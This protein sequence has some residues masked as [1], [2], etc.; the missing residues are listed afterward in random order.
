MKTILCLL[1]GL[2][3]FAC[4]KDEESDALA[5]TEASIAECCAEDGL[6]IEDALAEIGLDAESIYQLP[7]KFTDTNGKTRVL[8]DFRDRPVVVAMIFTH[9]EYACPVIIEDLHRFEAGLSEAE[10]NAVHWVLISFDAERD[11]PGVLAE[12]AKNNELDLSRWT[13]LHTDAAGVREAAA[14]L[15]VRYKQTPTGSF[16][17]ANRMTVLDQ[18]G[19]IH[20]RLDGLNVDVSPGIAALQGLLATDA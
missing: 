1:C 6:E 7:T 17:H 11:T 3:C 14:V 2:L 5:S 19:R 10:R 4:S 16:S 12:Y 9:C 20:R 8:A 13:L 18:A 15:G